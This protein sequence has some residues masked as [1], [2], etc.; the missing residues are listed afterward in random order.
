MIM[1][2]I[3]VT[4]IIFAVK[5]YI[6]FSIFTSGS[7]METIIIGLGT[8]IDLH[9]EIDLVIETEIATEI[10]TET[11]TKE[12]EMVVGTE[13]MGMAQHSKIVKRNKR[14]SKRD[15]LV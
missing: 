11:E 7:V 9:I 5:M 1:I 6:H 4:K 2:E 14:P 12:I 15:I 8:E 10:M 3:V 13:M